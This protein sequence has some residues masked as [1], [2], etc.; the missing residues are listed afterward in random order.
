M[1]A[2]DNPSILPMTEEE[3]AKIYAKVQ[4]RRVDVK[5]NFAKAALA[6]AEQAEGDEEPEAPPVH[7]V[8][9]ESANGAA[10]K[11]SR[12]PVAVN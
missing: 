1:M 12:T 7:E 5:A 8:K 9:P 10:R 11:R 6:R 3:C 2:I 4:E